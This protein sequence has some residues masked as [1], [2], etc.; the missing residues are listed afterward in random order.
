VSHRFRRCPICASERPRQNGVS[1]TELLVAIAI[2][3]VLAALLLLTLGRAKAASLR[4]VCINDTA[5]PPAF[6]FRPPSDA[7]DFSDLSDGSESCRR[8]R[9]TESSGSLRPEMRIAKVQ[10]MERLLDPFLSL[11]KKGWSQIALQVRCHE[12]VRDLFPSGNESIIC[13]A[14]SCTPSR[15]LRKEPRCLRAGLRLR[16]RQPPGAKPAPLR[17]NPVFFRVIRIAALTR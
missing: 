14:G 3:A 5:R 13:K 15:Y 9:R 4:V 6:A 11:K 7:S 17:L 8:G 2:V 12:A 16:S 10:E 1:L